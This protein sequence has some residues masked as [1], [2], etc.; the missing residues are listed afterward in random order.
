MYLKTEIKKMAKKI[1]Q[2]WQINSLPN[3][4]KS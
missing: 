4:I 3:K 1:H 2:Y